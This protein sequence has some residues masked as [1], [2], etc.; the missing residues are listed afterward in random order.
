MV[1][2]ETHFFFIDMESDLHSIIEEYFRNSSYHIID[3]IERGEK[4][5]KVVELFLDNKES[6]N[7]DE[8]AKI[9]RELNVLVGEKVLM[10][11]ISKLV[12]SSPGV[13]RPF[14]YI[15]QLHKHLGRLLQI[16]LNDGERLEGR[17]VSIAE[18]ETHSFSLDIL[19]KRNKKQV[20]SELR[21]LNFNNIKEAKVKI[22][23][24]K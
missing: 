14:K 23:F 1:G 8:L 24:S 5:T 4:G 18:N 3:F 9:N 16:E 13:E 19:Q 20:D 10:N 6:V 11:D 22:S 21:E 2:Y 17:L 7:I 12:V 15:W